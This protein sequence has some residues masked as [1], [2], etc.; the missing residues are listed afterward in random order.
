M[1]IDAHGALVAMTFSKTFVSFLPELVVSVLSHLYAHGL[2]E[3]PV[4]FVLSH[5]YAHGSVLNYD[6]TT[7]LK[8]HLSQPMRLGP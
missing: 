6:A 4:Q 1:L 3:T 8:T 7:H 2:P 5:L